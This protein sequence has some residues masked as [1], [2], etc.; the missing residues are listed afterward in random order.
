MPSIFRLGALRTV[1]DEGRGALASVR[2]TPWFTSVV[3]GVL[4]LGIGASVTMFSVFHAVVLR[5][6]PFDEP[7]RLVWLWSTRTDGS[8]GPFSIQDFVDLRERDTGVAALGAFA[9][10]S[11]NL[12]GVGTP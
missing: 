7:D 12:T 3:A 11:V 6:L 9:T 2:R 1:I 4:A 8:R 5:P 10:L